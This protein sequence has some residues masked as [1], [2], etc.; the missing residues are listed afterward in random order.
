[1]ILDQTENKRRVAK[2]YQASV[3]EKDRIACYCAKMRPLREENE[4]RAIDT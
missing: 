1:M 3:G 2:L 4:L